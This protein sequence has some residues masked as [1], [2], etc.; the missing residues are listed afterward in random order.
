MCSKQNRRFKFKCL[1]IITRTNE[2]KILTK[3]ISCECK[4]KFDGTKCNSNR[5]WNN[6]K[7]HVSAK[8]QNNI[9]HAKNSHLE[10]YYM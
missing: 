3:H 9:M 2:S 4:C 6:D 8:I 7:C 5:K 10:P 1:N